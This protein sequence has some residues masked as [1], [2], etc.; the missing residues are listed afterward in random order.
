MVNMASV[1]GIVDCLLQGQLETAMD[2]IHDILTQPEEVNGIKEF[3]ILIQ[4]AARQEE[5][6]RS[7]IKDV[8]KAYMSMKDNMESVIAED[9]SADAIGEEINLLQTQ[10]QKALQTSEAAKEQCQ[11]LNEEREK[12][13]AEQ[14][15]LSQKRETVKE[16]T[17]QVLPKTR[18][19]VSLYS[20]ITGI[21]WD[22][23]CKPDEIKG[24]VSTSKDVRPFSLDCKQHSKFFTT[25]Y[26]WDLVEAAV[27]AK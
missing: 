23:D 3:S 1:E 5:I 27:E 21:K 24:Y 13:H 9:K 8:L 12:M 22:Y 20:C 26:L 19:N 14:E 6:H 15:A 2:N 4:E 18:Y 7:H 16:D 10:H 11:A 17:T 25:N